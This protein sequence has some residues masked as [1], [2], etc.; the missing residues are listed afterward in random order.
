MKP[1]D[2]QQRAAR[3]AALPRPSFDGT[4]P[5]H[6]AQQAIMDAVRDHPVVIVCGETGSGKTTQI[7]KLC[8]A[9]GR[10]VGGLIGCTQPRRIAARSVATRLAQ[11]LHTEVGAV[12]GYQVRFHDRVSDA[13]FVK[14]MTDGILLSEIHH[15]RLLR[16]YD[17][18]VIDEAHERSLNIDFLLGY[19]KRLLPKR[20]DLK[21]IITSATMESD[22]LSRHFDGAPVLE[23]SGRTYP[24]DVRWRPVIASE[25]DE[26]EER[27]T[28]AAL[29]HAVD[30]LMLESNNGDVLVFLPG[31]R[32]IREAAE[33]LRKHHPPHTEILPL[34]AR[35][36]FAEQERV[37]KPGG[38]RRIVLA[39]NVAETSLTVPGIR[40]VVDTGL[41]RVNRYSLRNKV[42]QL[43]VEKIS[44][45]SARQRAGRC[46]RVSAGVC[47]RLYDEQDFNTRPP[48][49][50]PEILRTSLA[51]V[52]LRM[53]ALGLGKVDAFP[54]LDPPSP[55]A[56]DDGYQQ[57]NELSAIDDE[58]QLT[59]V[60][61][62]LARLPVD[63]RIG[64]MLLAA[65]QHDCLSEVLI[66]AA[67]L[68]VQDP[69]DRPLEHRQA[70]DQ[71]HAR[72]QHEQSEFMSYLALWK[73][74]EE[75]LQHRKS[76]RKLWAHFREEFLS[77]T[78]L[79]EWRDIHSQLHA[80]ASDMGL[81]PN[82]LPAPY[83]QLHR[84]LLAG[85]LGQVGLRDPEDDNYQGPRGV[86][87]WISPGS[88]LTKA[89]PKWLMAAELA[90]TTRLYARC[91]ARIEPEW[92]EP[93]AGHLLRRSYFDPFW[94]PKSAQASTHEKVTLY[95]L[96]IV[97]KRR[98]R[99]GPIDPA[100]AR[101]LFIRHALV[102]GEFETRAPFFAHNQ[103]L[104]EEIRELEHKGRRQ[105]VL[106][107]E[108]ALARFYE[109]L[110]PSSVWSGERFE[111]WRR[112]AEREQ[113]RLLFLEKA[114]LMRHEAGHITESLFPDRLEL[115]DASHPLTYRFE[116]GH[117]LDG[118]TLTVPLV[119]LP[120]LD[121]HRLEWLVPGLIRE[122][123][124][125]LLKKLPQR[126]RRELVPLPTFITAFL[127]RYGP[128]SGSLTAS[129]SDFIRRR[130]G[131]ELQASDWT[132]APEH[133]LMNLRLLNDQGE[134][135]TSGRDLEALRTTWGQEARQALRAPQASGIERNGITRWDFGD[136][137][138]SVQVH[139][140]GVAV[141]GFPALV[142]E[143]TEVS[144]RLMTSAEEALHSSRRGLM[145]L[146]LLEWQP[147]LKAVGRSISGLTNLTL[148]Y[149]LLPSGEPPTSAADAL[150]QELIERALDELLP[151]DAGTVRTQA[152]YETLREQTR[153]R[154]P[155]K[156][157]EVAALAGQALEAY[158][159]VRGA[160]DRAAHP[161]L[162]AALGDIRTHLDALM[163]RGTLRETALAQLRHFPRYLKAALLRL[164]KLPQDP[165][166]DAAKSGTLKPFETAWAE[167]LK[168]QGLSPA[169]ESFRWMMEELRV[170]LFA[171]ALRTPMPV[172]E[173]RL[174]KQ[175]EMLVREE[176]GGK[177]L[178]L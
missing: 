29:L 178:K 125:A 27:D 38:G 71:K 42:T 151:D 129:L 12:V 11:E 59:A 19:L 97:P 137:P 80:L 126:V 146:M 173:V 118:V 90:E 6:A 57:L 20:P 74:T 92:I 138:N 13:T 85:L 101:R 5:I 102:L 115:G 133:L 48:Y 147:Q 68:S 108:E 170:S 46:G 55:R 49:T 177:K 153:P 15:D 172:S 78:R 160:L 94:D 70:A 156:I 51:S 87:F 34:F 161:R 14:V 164:Q 157:Q 98:V 24:V 140:R 124:A 45:A 2:A 104:I 26:P 58:R 66:I 155:Q 113:P 110:L 60:G 121:A 76:G 159:E 4:L 53:E 166:G 7:P 52:I 99:L 69:R 136:L 22:R 135:V 152:G 63:P 107:D 36:S 17:T 163:H 144:I 31:E 154:L 95:G 165:A 109:G 61:R 143:G 1:F 82:S 100:E 10:G 43:Q 169:L 122:K 86:R 149:A 54:F 72:F 23:V 167:H 148:G 62:E 64:R 103:R 9:L 41:A 131:T 84:A 176:T 3:A 83:E 88:K 30:E 117:P 162:Q 139:S 40:F 132:A 120:Q 44:Q 65:R 96:P 81:R 89:K 141:P 158:R 105:D 112:E 47:I 123:I 33:A 145:R 127:E 39:T 119:L 79:R 111:K 171:Q 142:D 37:F 16:R 114:Q 150:K 174:K 168:R 28:R 175:W 56:I 8:L 116:P 91:V 93:I 32:D 18:L 106:V 21:V 134:E 25:A 67:A 50:T 77:L 128:Q 73:F 75:A 35:Q 130:T